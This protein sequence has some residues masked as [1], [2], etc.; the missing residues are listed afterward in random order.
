M[1]KLRKE[2]DEFEKKFE[3]ALLD[4]QGDSQLT[5]SKLQ[6]AAK[7]GRTGVRKRSRYEVAWSRSDFGKED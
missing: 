6:Y 4:M 1:S 2:V 3:R 5:D 7:R